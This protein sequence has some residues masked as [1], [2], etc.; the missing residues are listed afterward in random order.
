[1]SETMKPRRRW[2]RFSLRTLF[3]LLTLFGIWLGIQVKW[4]RDRQAARL[5][6]HEHGFIIA[7]I[8]HSASL[9]PP[10]GPT[11]SPY[12]NLLQSDPS[13]SWRSH[14]TLVRPVVEQ[15]A[16]TGNLP[17]SLK[18]LGEEPAELIVIVSD[19]RKLSEEE[20]QYVERLK[21]LF[22]EASLQVNTQA[23]R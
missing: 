23:A 11:V 9:V 8:A 16:P 20:R 4:V 12:L 21:R 19:G 14:R 17:W 3:V 7:D 18:M 6:V 5:W 22:P 13:P 1:M 15:T 2:F 10:N